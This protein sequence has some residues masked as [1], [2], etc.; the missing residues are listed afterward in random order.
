MPHQCPTND[1]GKTGKPLRSSLRH[2]WGIG[3]AFVILV[4]AASA[5]SQ[6]KQPDKKKDPPPKLL[7]AVPLVAKP[8]E[9]QKLTL[10]GKSLA[11]VKEVTVAGAE[12]AKVKVLGAKA[13]AVPNNYPAERVGDSEVEIELELPKD[14]KPGSVK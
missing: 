6:E 14:A 9:K 3:G 10:R 1:E 11:G 4:L 2:W 5:S 8:D 7:Y 12:G 13:V